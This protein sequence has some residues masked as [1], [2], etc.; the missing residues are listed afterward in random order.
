MSLA[1]TDDYD[2]TPL[3]D[4][5]TIRESKKESW[6][7][8]EQA[9]HCL[10]FHKNGHSRDDIAN[11]RPDLQISCGEKS[12]FN[13][14]EPQCRPNIRKTEGRNPYAISDKRLNYEKGKRSLTDS[15]P[16]MIIK[17]EKMEL[18]QFWLN[19]DLVDSLD[20]REIHKQYLTMKNEMSLIA[21]IRK[22]ILSVQPNFSNDDD[23]YPFA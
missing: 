10:I 8:S 18:S 22:E 6:L 20:M 7:K 14:K 21:E 19:S 11:Y 15:S 9:S 13:N 23:D 16:Q 3:C 17:Q 1:N 2:C 12:F 5:I 4:K